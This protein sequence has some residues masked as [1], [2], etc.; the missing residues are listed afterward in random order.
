MGETVPAPISLVE[1]KA[2]VELFGV[3]DVEEF[4]ALIKA[5]D[6]AYL[7]ARGKKNSQSAASTVRSDASR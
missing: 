2:Y 4:V 3:V 5:A 7:G 1:I 6:G